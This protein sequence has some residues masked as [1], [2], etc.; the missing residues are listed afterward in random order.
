MD[1]QT[2]VQESCVQGG[3]AVFLNQGVL[4]QMLP[5]HVRML[6]RDIVQSSGINTIGNGPSRKGAGK[7]PVQE[8]QVYPTLLPGSCLSN[9]VWRN[10][11]IRVQAHRMSERG[12]SYRADVGILPFFVAP[13]GSGHTQ[14]CKAR[15]GMASKLG[16]PGQAVGLPAGLQLL[17]LGQVS[18]I[19]F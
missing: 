6:G 15:P 9:P 3:E 8:Y 18:R 12:V 7:P 11:V 10:I 13:S 2:I 14:I 5:K 19:F 4:S 1:E 17:I 16:Q